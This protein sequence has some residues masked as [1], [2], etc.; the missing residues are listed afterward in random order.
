LRPVLADAR[1]LRQAT[2][3]VIAN[4]I[5]Y[6]EAGGQVLGDEVVEPEAGEGQLDPPRL[7]PGE[8]EEVVDEADDATRSARRS[9]PSSA[10]PR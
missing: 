3:N 9:T 7:D 2:M 1:S 4:A 8:V 6:T 10:S 5:T